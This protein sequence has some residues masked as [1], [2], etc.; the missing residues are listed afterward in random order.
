MN[1][2]GDSSNIDLNKF[3]DYI[4]NQFPAQLAELVTTRDELR[5]RQGSMDAVAQANAD[6]EAAAALLATA[7]TDSDALMSLANSATALA[8]A[9]E[10]QTSKDRAAFEESLDIS[11][12][13]LSR[14][15]AVLNDKEV[16]MA[17]RQEAL[18]KFEDD[19]NFRAAALDASR[20]EL[21][22]RVAAFQAKVAA[23]TA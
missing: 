16:Q 9:N 7:K 10:A 1:V 18:A 17:A 15:E 6:R 21:D 19:L 11:N 5:Q 14:R 13:A 2:Q 22:S 3:L 4:T 8:Q 23:L 20:A 12:S